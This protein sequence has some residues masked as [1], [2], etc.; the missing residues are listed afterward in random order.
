MK[1][2]K[3]ASRGLVGIA[4]TMV[5]GSQMMCQTSSAAPSATG[6]AATSTVTAAGGNAAQMESTYQSLKLSWDDCNQI[7]NTS[8]DLLREGQNSP[9]RKSW[10]DYYSDTVS[11]AVAKLESDWNSTVFPAAMQ[12]SVAKLITDAQDA[13][14]EMKAKVPE[15]QAGVQKVTPKNENASHEPYWGPSRGLESSA[16]KLNDAITKILA[17]ISANSSTSSSE[18][19]ATSTSAVASG[20]GSGQSITLQGKASKVHLDSS[21]KSV[22]E[23]GKKINEACTGLMGELE[24]WNLL[25]GHPPQGGT[26]DMFYG[27]G[28]TKQEVLTQ[29]RYLPTTVFTMPSYVK[30][31]SYRLPP[32]QNMLVHFTDQIG[33][34]LNLMQGELEAVNTSTDEQQAIAGPWEAVKRNFVAA[35]NQY[36]T[37]LKLVNASSD[38]QLQKS[39]REDEVTIGAP[40][41]AIVDT[42]TQLEH[43]IEDIKKSIASR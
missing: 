42:M 37:L 1:F 31:Y 16:N 5:A 34:L 30:L 22:S 12:D 25:Y 40:V 2:K 7:L 32:R 8:Q 6:A 26:A 39:I 43:D 19:T 15:L 27:G 13:I 33:K 3:F 29:Y 4:L 24:R 14:R 41:V 17:T 35:R 20:S 11:G 21:L 36:L 38:A 28:L 9:P 18:A 10:L 23:A